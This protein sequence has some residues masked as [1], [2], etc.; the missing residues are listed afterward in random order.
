MKEATGGT[1]IALCGLNRFLSKTDHQ[2]AGFEIRAVT[3][4]QMAVSD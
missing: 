2:D 3:T 1:T 4:F